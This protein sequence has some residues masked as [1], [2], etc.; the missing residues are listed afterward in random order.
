MTV[1]KAEKKIVTITLND[2]ILIFSNLVIVLIL[3]CIAS[4]TYT[5]LVTMNMVSLLVHVDT[6][7]TKNFKTTADLKMLVADLKISYFNQ[8]NS[9]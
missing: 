8:W 1:S 7:F 5:R 9:V 3:D 4:A 6:I 2:L